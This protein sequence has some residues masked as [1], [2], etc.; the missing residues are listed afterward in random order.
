MHGNDGVIRKGRDH[1]EMGRALIHSFVDK[2]SE[3]MPH[4][5]RTMEDGTR[6]TLLAIPNTYKQID[7]LHDVDKTLDSMSL[8]TMSSTSFNRIWNTKFANVTLSKTSEFSKCVVCS[9]IKSQ[10]ESTKDEE[11]IVLQTP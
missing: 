4:K 9:R 6:E 3:R 10:L 11:M 1:I 7:N 2:D 5:S 8:K